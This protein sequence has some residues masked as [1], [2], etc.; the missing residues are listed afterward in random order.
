[1]AKPMWLV[2]EVVNFNQTL[3]N[4]GSFSGFAGC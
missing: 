4:G 1:M 2:L 3:A